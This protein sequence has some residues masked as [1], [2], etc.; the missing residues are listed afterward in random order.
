MSK[1]FFRVINLRIL[2]AGLVFL[3]VMAVLAGCGDSIQTSSPARPTATAPAATPTSNP[4]TAP[5]T[6]PA[7]K[8]PVVVIPPATVTPFSIEGPTATPAATIP[9]VPTGPTVTAPAST[10]IS[11]NP[12]NTPQSSPN[13]PVATP[14]NN[15]T[16]ANAGPPPATTPPSGQ[17]NGSKQSASGVIFYLKDNALMV[18]V[19]GEKA[20][21]QVADKVFSYAQAGAGRVVFLQQSGGGTTRTM[22]LKMTGL[23]NGQL[24]ESVLDTRLFETLP[25]GQ[26]TDRPSGLYG[27]DTRSMGEIAVSPDGSQVAYTK[28][29]LSGPTFEGMSTNEK[30]TELWLANL[31][32]ANPSP[33]RLA[34]NDK[35]YIAQPLWSPDGNR[36]AFIRT[37]AFGTGAGYATA[38]WSVYKDGS[39][40]AFLTGPDLGEVGG[41]AF[42]AHPAFNLRWVNPHTL[43]FQANNQA[44][45]PIF[46]HDL[47]LGRDF[48]VALATDAAPGAVYCDG[49]QRFIYLK[50]DDGGQTQ[51]GAFSVGLTNPANQT[52]TVDK[53]AAELYGCEGN[54]LLYLTAKNQ[55][56]LAR[57]N[58]NGTAAA[59]KSLAIDQGPDVQVLAKLAPGGK[60]AAVQ[61]GKITRVL[62]DSGQI[63]DLKTGSFKYETLNLEWVSDKALVG[64]AFNT[65]QPDQILAA[66]LAGEQVFKAVDEGKTLI[67]AGPD[68]TAKGNF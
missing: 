31:D 7:E 11:S 15:G 29:N 48:P 35:D 54:N 26:Q 37:T 17:P 68:R 19:T 39:R 67:F 12:A 51:P 21:R 16:T 4:T 23:N 13:T 2:L 1:Q 38:L 64:L 59:S 44:D 25:A 34:P 22:Q 58:S 61:S 18:N 10:P 32:P 36:I 60:L 49:I 56:V 52:G 42:S 5:A 20:P 45:F 66:N 30:P 27:V 33:K 65:D 40:L 41:E 57:L 46:L 9:P 55:V 63:T 62:A 50:T 24:Q 43:T 3:F 8:Q 53:E 14:Q 6:T 47:S 28:A